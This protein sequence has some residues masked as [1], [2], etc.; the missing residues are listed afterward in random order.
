MIVFKFFSTQIFTGKF[1]NNYPDVLD[2]EGIFRIEID[3]KLFFIQPDFSVFEF[4]MYADDWITNNKSKDMQYRCLDTDENPLISFILKNDGWYI[5]SPWQLF[6]C[7]NIFSKEELVNAIIK[8]KK[9]INEQ[10]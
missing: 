3:D 2:Y 10:K 4:L 6:Q 5:Y 1:P 7:D 9:S 8:L